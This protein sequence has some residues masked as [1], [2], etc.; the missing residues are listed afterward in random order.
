MEQC[1]DV[2]TVPGV[3]N[4]SARHCGIS[5]STVA[6]GGLG[7]IFHQEFGGTMPSSNNWI[8]VLNQ[9]HGRW[10]KTRGSCTPM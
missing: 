10:M 1:M 9:V 6:A 4:G 8:E 3:R 7:G 2:I 5:A